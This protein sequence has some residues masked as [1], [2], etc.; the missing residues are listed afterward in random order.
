MGPLRH[1]QVLGR[2]GVPPAQPA[3]DVDGDALALVEQA[4]VRVVTCASTSSRS[5]RFGT[6]W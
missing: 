4:S 1:G 3:P 5:S 2:L 6:E